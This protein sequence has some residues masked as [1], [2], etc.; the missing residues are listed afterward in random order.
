MENAAIGGQPLLEAGPCFGFQNL[1]AA[2]RPDAGPVMVLHGSLAVVI[3]EF[4]A[5]DFVVSGCTTMKTAA[6]V[7]LYEF[8]DF[9][10]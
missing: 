10:K 4:E 9:L 8:H 5:C 1:S 7:F 3:V 6:V 2:T